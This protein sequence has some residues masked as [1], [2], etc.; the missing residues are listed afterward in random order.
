MKLIRR[1]FHASLLLILF[2]FT[3]S[4]LQTFAQSENQ[5]PVEYVALGDSLAHGYLN[6][7]YSNESGSIILGNGYPVFIE[8]GIK[9]E[10]GYEVRLTNGGFSGYQTIHVLEQLHKNVNNIKDDIETADFVTLGI[11]AN[12]L[13]GLLLQLDI[14]EIDIS[15]P[16]DQAKIEEIFA[17]FPERINSVGTNIAEII[18]EIQKVN[19]NAQIYVM[20]YYN[21][22]SFL[23]ETFQSFLIPFI[24][25]LNS[26]I[27][28]V[29]VANDSVYI[30]TFEAFVGKYENY[31]PEPD[32]HPN[33]AGYQIIANQFLPEIL[34]YVKSLMDTTKPEITLIGD[35]PLE[36][37]VGDEYVEPGALAED[38]VDG[39]LTD[40]I[41]ISG[42]VD[43]STAGT[44]TV[45]YTVSDTAGNVASI[46]RTVHVV[47]PKQS[48]DPKPTPAPTPPQKPGSETPKE[49]VVTKSDT[50]ETVSAGKTSKLPKT[51]TNHPLLLLIGFLLVT[52]SGAIAFL[53]RTLI[54]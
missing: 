22:L 16:E 6:E 44:Y 35:E 13:L 46:T 45:T 25:N 42:E 48:A 29:A 21:A 7:N 18:S 50:T 40:S 41:E 30:P 49:E 1:S 37:K 39:D 34:V 26:K 38:D 8:K 52:S 3:L 54:S 33:E 12:D 36:L 24:H 23:D 11:G 32:I 4:P 5:R 2:L 27:Q 31:F 53:R 19:S 43:T 15:N 10:L 14:D 51:A 17:Q 28:D 9:N 47:E 20:G